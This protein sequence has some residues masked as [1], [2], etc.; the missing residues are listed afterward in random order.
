MIN[1]HL[2]QITLTEMSWDTGFALGGFFE[3][4]ELGEFNVWQWI[5]CIDKG[6]TSQAITPVATRKLPSAVQLSPALH[7]LQL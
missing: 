6:E 2:K 1:T 3:Y 5:V 7:L 4:I